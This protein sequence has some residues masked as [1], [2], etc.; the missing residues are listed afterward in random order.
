M[1]P[2][3][4]YDTLQIIISIKESLAK[5]NTQI[6]QVLN[7]LSNHEMRLVKLEEN[8]RSLKDDV[9]A[10]A[11]KGLVIGIIALGSVAGAGTLIGKFLGM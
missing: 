9:L 5:L 6:E 10:T 8:K 7:T 11:V 2:T 3:M 1:D 4:E